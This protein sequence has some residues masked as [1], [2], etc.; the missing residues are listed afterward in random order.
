[1]YGC[2]SAIRPAIGP[3]TPIPANPDLRI[4]GEVALNSNFSEQLKER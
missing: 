1:V 2:S 3:P 4:D